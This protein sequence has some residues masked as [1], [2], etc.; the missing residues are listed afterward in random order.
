MAYGNLKADN[1]IFADSNNN[2]VDTVVPLESVAGKAPLASPAFTGTPTAP[3][4]AADT[5]STQI[6]TTAYVDQSNFASAS[7]DTF[8]GDV[9]VGADTDGHDVKFFGDTTGK[10]CLWNESHNRLEIEGDLQVSDLA[11]FE[12][13]TSF[14]GQVNFIQASGDQHITTGTND[15]V[16]GQTVG[17]GVW[18]PHLT[19]NYDKFEAYYLGER[20]LET[21]LDGITVSS[22]QDRVGGIVSLGPTNCSI[23]AYNNYASSA[24][25]Y[26]NETLKIYSLHGANN[27]TN[28]SIIITSCISI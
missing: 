28:T 21:H 5:N 27:I 26:D 14:E 13:Q 18:A 16:F 11:T 2:N 25:N 3:T 19:L 8:T 17:N 10:Y 23:R 12:N 9:T 20:K 1:L 15:V 6:A 22:S 4:A 24:N 7:G